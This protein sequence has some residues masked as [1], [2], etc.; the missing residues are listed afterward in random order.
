VHE[1]CGN[2]R[3]W[4]VWDVQPKHN[5]VLLLYLIYIFFIHLCEMWVTQTAWRQNMGEL[6]L[7][8]GLKTKT[9]GEL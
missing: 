3:T 9:V 2:V 6:S 7:T 8:N 5:L 4:G 1:I